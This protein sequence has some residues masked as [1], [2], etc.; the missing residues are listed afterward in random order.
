MTRA[1]RFAEPLLDELARAKIIGVRAGTAHRFT[2]VWVIVVSGRVFVRSWNDKLTGRY[3]AFQN[4]PLGPSG[5]RKECHSTNSLA[6]TPTLLCHPA[7][8]SITGGWR[9]LP[10]SFLLKALE[11]FHSEC[12]SRD[13]NPDALP[14]ESASGFVNSCRRQHGVSSRRRGDPVWCPRQVT[15]IPCPLAQ[16]LS[17]LI[18]TKSVGNLDRRL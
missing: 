10:S 4:E 17:D 12:E 2:G 15:P 7:L 5:M 16:W 8:P 11:G 6:V 13:L 14:D 18:A 9:R 3:R 1:T